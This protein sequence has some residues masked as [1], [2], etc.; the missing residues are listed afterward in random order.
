[1]F[2]IFRNTHIFVL[3][4]VFVCSL[5][6]C[7]KQR[8]LQSRMRE[9]KGVTFVQKGI[10]RMIGTSS[11]ANTTTGLSPHISLECH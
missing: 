6:V 9:G 3:S 11:V 4:A 2:F 5:V 1:M 8:L 7:L 10:T